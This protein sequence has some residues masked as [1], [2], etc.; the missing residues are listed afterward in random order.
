M[1]F[2]QGAIVLAADPFKDGVRPFVIVNTSEHPFHGKQYTL[3]TLSTQDY[4]AGIEIHDDFLLRGELE[5]RSFALPWSLSSAPANDV[6]E[7]V[8][9]LKQSVVEQ[10]INE[11]VRY[12]APDGSETGENQHPLAST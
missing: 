3:M 9:C 6:Y 12:V 10:L 7:Q 1:A 2:Q 5:R 8:A 11:L 4:D